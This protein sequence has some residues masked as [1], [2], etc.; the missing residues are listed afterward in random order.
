MAHHR[1][2]H[3]AQVQVQMHGLAVLWNLA[4]R[5]RERAGA[6]R[7]ALGAREAARRALAAHPHDVQLKQIRKGLLRCL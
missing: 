4:S 2:Q 1:A 7:S 5:S 3:L 6:I